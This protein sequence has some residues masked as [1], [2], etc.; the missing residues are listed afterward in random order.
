MVILSN[1][2]TTLTTTTMGFGHNIKRSMTLPISSSLSLDDE[3]SS[4][5]DSS[6]SLRSSSVIKTD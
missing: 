1:E 6:D 5:P 3:L 4:D 2:T